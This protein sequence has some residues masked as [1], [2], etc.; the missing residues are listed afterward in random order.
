MKKLFA[1]WADMGK[2]PEQIG[3]IIVND[4]NT[5]TINTHCGFDVTEEQVLQGHWEDITN[6]GVEG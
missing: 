2:G 4:D 6:I 3:E 5:V 1:S